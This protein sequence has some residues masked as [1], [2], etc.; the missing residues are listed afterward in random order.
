METGVEQAFLDIAAEAGVDW[1]TTR[2]TMREAGRY[3]VE[4]Y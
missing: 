1:E 4:T 3:H 2:N